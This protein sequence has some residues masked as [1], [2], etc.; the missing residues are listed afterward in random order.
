M[1]ASVHPLPAGHQS[2]IPGGSG[3]SPTHITGYARDVEAGVFKGKNASPARPAH[4]LG[5]SSSGRWSADSAWRGTRPAGLGRGLGAAVS[6]LPHKLGPRL[7]IVPAR[8][9][10]GSELRHCDVDVIQEFRQRRV[11]LRRV[12]AAGRGL[13]RHH[14]IPRPRQSGGVGLFAGG[15]PGGRSLPLGV[16]DGLPARFGPRP[17]AKSTMKLAALLARHHR[18]P[19]RFAGLLDRPA[20][21][22]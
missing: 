9:P 14:P 17:G 21:H 18:R 11:D 15:P 7:G 1:T 10:G 22:L 16:G 5:S 13:L 4:S 2:V 6:E 8:L 20:P 3:H 12:H 19:A